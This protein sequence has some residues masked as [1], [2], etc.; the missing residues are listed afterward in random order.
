MVRRHAAEWGI[1][2]RKIGIMGFSAG[3]HL[4]S[5]V[6][7]HYRENVYKPVD[8]T[9]AR[10][11][12]SLLIYPVISMDSSITH[13]G[14]RENLLGKNPSP[15]L[16]HRFSNQLQVDSQTPPAFLMHSM[17][18]GTVPVENSIEYALA[19]K[20][21]KVPCELHIYERGGHGFGL[22]YSKNTES[23]WPA[24]CQKWLQANGFLPK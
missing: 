22:G 23:T 19:L 4:A 15:E 12:F 13:W 10:P 5:T 7:T 24:A 3:G 1:N 20:K 17:D 8:T 2:P 16:L 18:D 21:N 11:D 9:S 14:S 6:S